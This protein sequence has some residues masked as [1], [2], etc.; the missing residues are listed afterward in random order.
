M[1]WRPIAAALPDFAL[2]AVLLATWIRPGWLGRD[3][4]RHGVLMMLVEFLVV[5]AFGFL[6]VAGHE[7]DADG[8]GATLAVLGLGLFYLLFT[9]V[10]GY[11]FR[12]WWP[13]FTIGWLIASKLWS[14][15]LASD[16]ATAR[17]MAVMVWGV[18]TAAYFAGAVLTVLLPL[19]RLGVRGTL[20]DYGMQGGARGAWV[21]DP[22]RALAFGVLYFS[23][24]GYARW[25]FAN[26]Y[27]LAT[28]AAVA[29]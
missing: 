17:G 1:E 7:A 18:S 10:F 8:P 24:V 25:W 5:H 4:V 13:V 14:L 22:H 6:F 15:H 2:A 9:A 12:S 11:A 29:S 3:W 20:R 28:T 19:P 16:D 27:A 26:E 23:A 21:D